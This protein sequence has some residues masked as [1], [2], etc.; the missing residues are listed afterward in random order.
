PRPQPSAAQPGPPNPGPIGQTVGA[1]SVV[2]V[3]PAAHRPW[4]TAQQLGDPGR[5]PVLLGDQDHD[6]PVADP[7]GAVQQAKQVT[8][9]TS[10]AGALGV[11]ARGTH[12][13]PSL[14]RSL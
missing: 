5:R 3:D 7:V 4:V 8:G 14:V 2:A 6:Q 11:H 13:G 9:V 10:R 12:T 1:V